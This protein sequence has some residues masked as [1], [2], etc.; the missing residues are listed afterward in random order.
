MWGASAAADEEVYESPSETLK[1]RSSKH[2]PGVTVSWPRSSVIVTK[3]KGFR[4]HHVLQEG[5]GG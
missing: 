3:R 5:G 1:L 2:K 4:N